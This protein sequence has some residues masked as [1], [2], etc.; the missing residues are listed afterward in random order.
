MT[1]VGRSASASYVPPSY[2]TKVNVEAEGTSP[3]VFPERQF[4]LHRFKAVFP[5][6][7][8]ALLRSHFSGSA[9]VAAFFGVDDHTA[10]DWLEGTTGPRG[11]AVAIACS[12]IPG[13]AQQLMGLAA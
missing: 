6:R 11:F 2:A 4:D 5:D 8:A 3:G 9:H 13:A 1:L 12:A 7:W 10:R